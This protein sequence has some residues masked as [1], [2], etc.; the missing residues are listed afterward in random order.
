MMT[1][2]EAQRREKPRGRALREHPYAVHILHVRNRPTAEHDDDIPLRVRRHLIRLLKTSH[3]TVCNRTD[4]EQIERKR[5][6]G[7]QPRDSPLIPFFPKAG[8]KPEH[9]KDKDAR[10]Q[11]PRRPEFQNVNQNITS[12]FEPNYG[13][14]EKTHLRFRKH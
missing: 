10:R 7:E 13:N 9:R 4:G 1:L 6:G 14:T 5:K 8:G 2:V 3:Q 12:S 11:N